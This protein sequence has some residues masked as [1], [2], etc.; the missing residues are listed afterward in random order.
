MWNTW[1]LIGNWL[2]K[3]IGI[4]MGWSFQLGD[5]PPSIRGWSQVKW[6]PQP[7][8]WDIYGMILQVGYVVAVISFV[9][10]T[11]Q[12]G[13][14]WHRKP[15]FFSGFDVFFKENQVRNLHVVEKHFSTNWH[16][17]FKYIEL[18]KIELSIS[19]FHCPFCYYWIIVHVLVFFGVCPKSVDEKT[20]KL[21]KSNGMLKTLV[22]IYSKVMY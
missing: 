20:R 7:M 12:N 19:N 9:G 4:S 6:Q 3:K 18:S 11:T 22:S 14:V 10:S 13:R 17:K 21:F 8:Y 5:D 1:W 15:C 16:W 2:G